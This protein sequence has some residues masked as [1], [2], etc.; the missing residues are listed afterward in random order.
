MK[1]TSTERIFIV[2]SIVSSCK[3]LQI[4]HVETV[5]SGMNITFPILFVLE[6]IKLNSWRNSYAYGI[7]W[8]S[9]QAE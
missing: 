5:L 7:T 2:L 9:I 6:Q 3:K 1:V 8:I 4:I